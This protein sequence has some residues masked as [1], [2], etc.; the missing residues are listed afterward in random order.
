MCERIIHNYSLALVKDDETGRA[1]LHVF[2]F[3]RESKEKE[4]QRR[5]NGKFY[6]LSPKR[7]FLAWIFFSMIMTPLM[8]HN[9]LLQARKLL[10]T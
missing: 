8:M 2:V 6:M 5:A 3:I 7:L 10:P 4:E 1:R 9:L